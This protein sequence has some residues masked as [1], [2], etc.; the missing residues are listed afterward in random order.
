MRDRLITLLTALAAL[1]LTIFL[2]TP[3]R[4][5]SDSPVSLPTTEDRGSEGL[6]G[7]YAWLARERLPVASLRKRYTGLDKFAAMPERGNV[8]IASLPA[9]REISKQEWRA[10]SD[11]VSKGNTLLILGAVHYRPSWAGG[12]NC[13]CDVKK[14]LRDFDWS[15]DWE[16]AASA[17]DNTEDFDK[18]TFREKV[19]AIQAGV[20]A[21]IP[22]PNKLLAVSKHPLL[23]AVAAVETKTG[24]ELL[25]KKW[26]L[27]AENPDNLALSLLK[28]SGGDAD[29]FW[30]IKTGAGQ[31]FLSLTP[32]LFSNAQL[33]K[34]DNARFFANLLGQAL[35]A[36]G[37]L[38]FDDFHFGL[39][40]LYD[41]E[42]F[43][44]DARL[45]KTLGFLGLLWL[46]YVIG[47]TD[48]LA[49]V[50][51]AVAKLSAR[52]FIDAAAGFFAR[53]IEKRDLAGELVKHLLLDISVCRQLRG[54]TEAWRWLERHPQ[55]QA[56]Q[57]ALLKQAG[58]KRR[59]SLQ[60][61]T[62]TITYIRKTTL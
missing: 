5:P 27:A 38:I 24:P 6:K 46:L 1:G 40:E 57:I 7:L 35:A 29:A 13:F 56:G 53:R 14:L 41:P 51:P 52:D 60:R 62:D 18:K 3:P 8:L 33:N 59:I 10:L 47:Y 21:R 45:H 42:R 22:V 23:N 16:R 9:P 50:R 34:A 44:N 39:S 31:V 48:R 4:P 37:K 58:Q 12:E 32:D 25:L 28:L 54:E 17:Q 11:W 49:P 43:F 15:L 30:Q 19:A 55:V 36:D 26:T 61:L 2:L 20:K